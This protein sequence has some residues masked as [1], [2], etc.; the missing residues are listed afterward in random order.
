MAFDRDESKIRPM[1]IVY[2]LMEVSQPFSKKI[3]CFPQKDQFY[4]NF[5]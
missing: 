5:Q 1:D 4:S 3:S 2:D